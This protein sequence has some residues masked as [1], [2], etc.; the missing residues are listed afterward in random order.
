MFAGQNIY[1]AWREIV[2]DN[3]TY[4]AA[5]SLD[6]VSFTGNIIGIKN[7]EMPVKYEL[8]QNYPNPFNPSTTINYSIKQSG[9]VTLKVYDVLGK[10]VETLVNEVKSSGSY[11]VNFDGTNLSNGVYFYKIEVGDFAAIKKMIL[12]K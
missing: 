4:G 6:L 7:N 1:I 11:N 5:I 8:S 10:E 3:L 12:L 2:T 9:L